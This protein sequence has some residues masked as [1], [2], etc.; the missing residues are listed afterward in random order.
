[1]GGWWSSEASPQKSTPWGLASLD[2]QPPDGHPL[3]LTT[4]SGGGEVSFALPVPPKTGQAAGRTGRIR[5]VP[6]AGDPCPES[7]RRFY[8]TSPYEN[9]P[10]LR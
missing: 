6:P 8:L 5:L 1:M 9:L 7:Q 3:E 2:H 10:F 4:L